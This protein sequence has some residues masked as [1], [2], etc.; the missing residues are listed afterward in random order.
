VQEGAGVGK[1]Q[2][3]GHEEKQ[4]QY[5]HVRKYQRIIKSTTIIIA[6]AT[7]ATMELANIPSALLLCLFVCLFACF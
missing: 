6:T 5:I 4:A 3:V 1:H 7:T 2:K